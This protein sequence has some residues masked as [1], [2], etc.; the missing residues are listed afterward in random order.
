MGQ[1]V[2]MERI[3]VAMS[4]GVDSSVAAAM[5]VD[6]GCEVIGITMKVSS[7]GSEASIEDAKRVASKLGIAHYVVDLCNIF[8]KHVIKSFIEEY[9]HGRT[10]NPCVICNRLI[11]FGELLKRAQSFGAQRIAT[12]HYAR[13]GYDEASGRRLLLRGKDKSKDQSYV[14]YR[15]TQEQLERAIFPLGDATKAKTRQLAAELGLDIAEKQDSQEICFAPNQDYP[16]FLEAA[17]PELVKPGQ[18]VTTDG[19][20]LGEHRGIAFYTVGQRKRLGISVGR[21]MY[22]VR[23]DAKTNTVVVG[24]DTDL[25]GTKVIIKDI[26]LISIEDIASDL[27][28][29]AKIRYNTKDSA[30]VVRAS[31]KNMAEVCFEQ[32]QRAITPGQSVVMYQ[33]DV[34]VGG[35]TICEMRSV[36]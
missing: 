28:V 15:L 32:P 26:N 29:T 36:E 33:K 23:I 9:R 30:A 3:A 2:K 20:V 14:L 27:A 35:G 6:Q 19:K 11:K 4:G 34:V 17:A 16:A 21:P 13:L 24:D 10:P 12:G 31:F 25:Y 18:I 1:A 8:N 5:L 7:Y 22:V